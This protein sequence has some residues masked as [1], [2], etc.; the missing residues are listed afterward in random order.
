MFQGLWIA[1]PTPFDDS[2]RLDVKSLGHFTEWLI[3]QEVDGIVTC[4]T[5]GEVATL[6]T[7]ERKAVIETVLDVSKGR[8][9]V[10]VGTGS[11]S[12]AS[13][14][15][16][17]E[18]AKI[19]GADAA[20]V[21][22]PYYNKPN[23]EGLVD[24]FEAVADVGLPICLYNVPGRTNVNLLPETVEKLAKNRHVHAIKEASGQISQCE[25]VLARTHGTCAFLSGDDGLY[26]PLLCLGA[27]GIVSVTGNL[28]PRLMKSMRTHTL[29]GEIYR[30]RA[31]HYKLLPLFNA[32]FCDTNPVPLKYA[33]SQL[34][35]MGPTVRS[36][37]TGLDQKKKD[38]IDQVLRK[39][40]LLNE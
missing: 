3:E 22:T 20:L 1:I 34:G 5:T 14:V 23:Q 37:L 26:F 17:T 30:A 15:K 16:W 2:H 33:L 32:L 38:L 10:M 12:T 35:M 8:V 36:P 29:A 7:D 19:L 11:N 28:A 39:L 18:E 27:D 21:V 4:G 24:Y 9:S 13:A 31:E 40:E 6:E 25:D